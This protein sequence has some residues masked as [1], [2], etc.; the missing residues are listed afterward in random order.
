MKKVPK[1]APKRA[2]K[3]T[4]TRTTSEETKPERS[5]RPAGLVGSDLQMKIP[6]GEAA[7]DV[8]D[9]A[10]AEMI[11][12]GIYLPT[13]PNPQ[14]SKFLDENGVPVLPRNVQELND[15]EIGELYSIFQRYN[16]YVLGQLA[17]VKIDHKQASKQFGFMSA[18]VRLGK[19]GKQ[20]DKD[21]RKMS[22]VRYVTAD[23]RAFHKEAVWI[24]LQKVADG[25]DADLKLISRNISLREQRLKI[26]GRGDAIGAKRHIRNHGD[27]EHKEEE[28]RE[29]RQGKE[30]TAKG[31]SA[32][33]RRAARK[34]PKR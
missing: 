34:V 32:P 12:M 25:L 29:R 31:R 17:T 13:R 2:P 8:S 14:E 22:D 26:G 4:R 24:L 18:K 7:Y 19:D 30:P 9:D 15:R 33:V 27:E 11:E 23:A 20:K 28:P 10:M 3:R 5:D 21:D 1:R 16:S 6:E